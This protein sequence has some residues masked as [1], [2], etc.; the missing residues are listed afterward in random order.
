MSDD[1]RFEQLLQFFKVLGNK[2]RL[3]ILGLL[4]NQERNV[5]E[6]ALM[7]DL[8][9]PTVSHHLGLLKELG[10]VDTR[11]EGNLRLYR[12]NQKAL[13]KMNK[14]IFS[15]KQLAALV[16][17]RKSEETWEEKVLKAF[18]ANGRLLDIPARRKKRLV[19]LTWLVQQ[20]DPTQ[21]YHELELNE[22]L[23]QF[24]E[25]CASLR[26]YMVEEQLLIRERNTYWRPAFVQTP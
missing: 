5:G 22:W 23:K 18:V 2:N 20:L 12:L 16:D 3:Q 21:Q 1:E 15:P 4:A 13:E 7:L 8:K 11:P 25:D 24:H 14:D 19:V 26:R 10:L 9:E 6:L 17:V